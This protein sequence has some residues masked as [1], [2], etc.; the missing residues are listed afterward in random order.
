M[1]KW[2]NLKLQWND[3]W[4]QNTLII[5]SAKGRER[6][7]RVTKMTNCAIT[8]FLFDDTKKSVFAFSFQFTFEKTLMKDNLGSEKREKKKHLSFFF[9]WSSFCVLG[10]S[11]R[12]NCVLQTTRIVLEFQFESIQNQIIQLLKI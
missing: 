10:Q 11:Y 12:G 7:T 5:D 9:Q 1:A 3:K 8:T 2:Q 4:W 6:A